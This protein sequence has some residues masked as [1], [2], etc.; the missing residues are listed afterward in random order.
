M[1]I[2]TRFKNEDKKR[3]LLIIW[4]PVPK[5]VKMCETLVNNVFRKKHYYSVKT[6]GFVGIIFKFY[7]GPNHDLF[8]ITPI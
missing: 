8:D 7:V 4:Y 6:H 1:S 5:A 2:I 3:I